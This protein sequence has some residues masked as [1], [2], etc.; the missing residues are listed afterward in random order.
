[1]CVRLIVFG[2]RLSTVP[3]AFFCLLWRSCVRGGSGESSYN[4]TTT[5]INPVTSSFIEINSLIVC[6]RA[7]E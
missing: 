5:R 2:R 6:L 7:L 1:M 3:F 4:V